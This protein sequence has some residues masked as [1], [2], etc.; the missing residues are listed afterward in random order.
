M[1]PPFSTV[2]D[3]DNSTLHTVTV[4]MLSNSI[5]TD[6]CKTVEIFVYKGFGPCL[7]TLFTG[8]SVE[9]PVENV[10]NSLLISVSFGLQY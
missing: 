3:L 4:V 1:C 5:S 8:S 6:L 9:K 7:S 10:E 2:S